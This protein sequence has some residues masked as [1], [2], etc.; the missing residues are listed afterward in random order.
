MRTV[1]YVDIDPLID[2]SGSGIDGSVCVLDGSDEEITNKSD[3]N[4][5]SRW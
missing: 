1:V 2:G 3:H 5:V 4:N